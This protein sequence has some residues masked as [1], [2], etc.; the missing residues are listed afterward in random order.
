MPRLGSSE[1]GKSRQAN[2]A[3]IK[4]TQVVDDYM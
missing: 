2:S 4:V 1:S 3:G